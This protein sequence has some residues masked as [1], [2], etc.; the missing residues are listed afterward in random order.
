MAKNIVICCDGTGNEYG[1]N[2]TNVVKMYQ[3]AAKSKSQVVYYDPG[4]GTGG[5]EYDESIGDMR[6]KGDQA[7]GYG[8]QKNVEDAYRYLMHYYEAGDKIFLFGF[9]RGAFTVR[10]LAGMLHKCGLL[11]AGMD[12]M[13]K[14][15]GKMY[16]TDKNSPIAAKFKQTFSRA[17]PVHFIGVWDTVASLALNAGKKFHD[18]HLNPEVT[19]GYHALALD[20]VREKFPPS[21]WKRRINGVDVEQVWFAGVH[22]DVGGWYRNTSLSDIALKWMGEKALACGMQLDEAKLQKIRGNPCGV[23]HDSHMGVMWKMMGKYIRN[24]PAGSKVHKSV[25]ARLGK[26]IAIHDDDEEQ[27]GEKVAYAPVATANGK[28][29]SADKVEWVD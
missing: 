13:V 10:S 3:L 6:A 19:H 8:L 15:A 26:K 9:S 27:Q 16:N 1:Q 22:S 18:A 7:T 23:Q 21:L 29:F 12:N 4:V 25:Q 2:N 14:Y 24:L 5:W 28:P 11:H 20:E 17:C